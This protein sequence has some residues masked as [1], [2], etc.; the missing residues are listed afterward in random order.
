MSPQRLPRRVNTATVT[1][2][3]V[4]PA[5]PA[6][7]SLLP[8]GQRRTENGERE[9]GERENKGST[10]IQT[11]PEAYRTWTRFSW[12][13]YWSVSERYPTNRRPQYLT[14]IQGSPTH[15]TVAHMN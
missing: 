5:L 6:P 1:W 2:T 13:T 11:V 4:R 7:C 12:C 15:T 8:P 3:Q 9:T 10:S 14:Y